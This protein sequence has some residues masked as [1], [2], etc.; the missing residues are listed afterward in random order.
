MPVQARNVTMNNT[1]VHTL[2]ASSG[3]MVFVGENANISSTSIASSK[4]KRRPPSDSGF[5]NTR[6]SKVSKS[7]ELDY[8]KGSASDCK[9][10]AL[11]HFNRIAEIHGGFSLHN[12]G[13][14]V[15]QKVGLPPGV[16]KGQH[17]P[18]PEAMEDLASELRNMV[19]ECIGHCVD[20]CVEE[21]PE[22]GAL[23][24]S[25][26]SQCLSTNVPHINEIIQKNSAI[27][28]SQRRQRLE[29]VTEKRRKKT[30]K[31]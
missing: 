24:G 9:Q 10:S 25:A 16:E 29:S 30:R 1:S 28:P 3:A 12:I 6:K 21:E 7:V 23:K 20:T 4:T 11:V 27:A 31:T 26:V 17:V 18:Y 5:E 15:K 13:V 14:Y 2:N 8:N 22:A 19:V